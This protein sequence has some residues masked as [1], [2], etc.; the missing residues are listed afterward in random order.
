MIIV[1]GGLGFIGFNI[2]KKFNSNNI[3]NL[4]IVDDL[5]NK[6]NLINKDK[7]KFKKL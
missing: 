6:N 7:I 2:I 4:I 5:K 3:S 1:T